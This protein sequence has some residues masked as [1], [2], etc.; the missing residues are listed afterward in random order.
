MSDA[1][2]AAAAGIP[3]DILRAIRELESSG[4]V[5]AVRFEPH[6]FNRETNDRYRSQIP[7][8]PDPTRGVSLVAS[9]TNRAAFER[10]STFNARAAIRSTS[11]GLYQVMGPALLRIYPT[12]PVGHFDRNPAGVSDELLV[13]W[14]RSR[15]AAVAAANARNIQELAR[16]YNG[17]Q[18]WGERL[19]TILGRMLPAPPAAACTW[20]LIGDSQGVGMKPHLASGFQ[21]RG[22]NLAAAFAN[23]GWSTRRTL[24]E[25]SDEIEAAIAQHEPRLV[26]IVLGGND[27]PG[28]AQRSATEDLIQLAR[29]GGATV[30]WVGP[31]HARDADLAQRKREV[32]EIQQ[33]VAIALGISW[34]NGTEMTKDL[35]HTPDGVHFTL[36]SQK[37]W[38]ER[39]VS[40]LIPATTT[41]WGL[42]RYLTPLAAFLPLFD[43][44]C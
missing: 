1:T 8:T 6:V 35:T 7:F 3:V 10:A 23:V 32:S 41:L 38:A 14:F 15:P 42:L 17:S 43:R 12:D 9:E 5:N 19:M 33:A 16:L 26:L 40:A 22:L 28:D 44:D 27:T 30:V 4:R 31:A 36:A 2:L 37:R 24:T 25:L 39:I 34:L 11:W 18:R 21:T 29:K 13:E 20:I